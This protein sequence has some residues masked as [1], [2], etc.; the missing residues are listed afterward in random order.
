MLL[1]S[2]LVPQKRSNCRCCLDAHSISCCSESEGVALMRFSEAK[3]ITKLQTQQKIWTGIEN[4]PEEWP[5]AL[6]LSSSFL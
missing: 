4:I 1:D 2:S 5:Y 6:V 3:F